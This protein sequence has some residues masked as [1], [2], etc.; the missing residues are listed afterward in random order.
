M[1]IDKILIEANYDK[2]VSFMSISI[3]M[4]FPNLSK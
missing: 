1:V 3:E 2:N 4:G